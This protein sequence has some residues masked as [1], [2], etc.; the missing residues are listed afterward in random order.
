M[1]MFVSQIFGYDFVQILISEKKEQPLFRNDGVKLVVQLK[2]NVTNT[3]LN[4]CVWQLI[5]L[6]LFHSVCLHANVYSMRLTQIYLFGTICNTDVILRKPTCVVYG[7][8]EVKRKP[9]QIFFA[10]HAV[11]IDL[12]CFM[13]L[14]VPF[15]FLVYRD[16]CTFFSRI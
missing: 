10:L 1:V 11:F 3:C 2:V 4:Q 9:N 5:V 16:K 7:L 12:R 8:V 6:D 14:C 15:C 13:A